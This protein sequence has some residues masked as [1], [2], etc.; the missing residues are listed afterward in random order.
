MTRLTSPSGDSERRST[1]DVSVVICAYTLDRLRILRASI[2]SVRA[3]EHPASEI[4]VVID[5]NPELLDE[6]RDV[7]GIVLVEN[8]E[9]AGLSGARNTGVARSTSPLIA[10]LDDDAVAS[11]SWLAEL[12]APFADENVVMVGGKANPTWLG[13]RPS[14]FPETFGWVVG[15]SFEG[16]VVGEARNPIGC[17]MAIRRAAVDAVGGFSSHVGRTS[18]SLAGGEET[19]LAIQ[20]RAERPD[21]RVIVLDGAD[22]AHEVPATRGTLKYFLRRCFDEGAS[23]ALVFDHTSADASSVERA[24]LTRVL[25]KSAGRALRTG[26]V[27]EA[28]AITA[29]VAA[30]GTGFVK[31]AVLTRLD[32]SKDAVPC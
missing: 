11:P 15:C 32:R 18:R 8:A 1:A 12:I 29:G 13:E 3:Q 27:G 2:A 25:P 24:Y 30:T 9:A 6:L 5:H 10:F 17:N 14:W 22:V 19:Q 4:V 26:R 28:L 7:P 23:K 20:I 21:S 16:Q 31:G